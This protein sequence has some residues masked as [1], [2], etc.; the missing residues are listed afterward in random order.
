MNQNLKTVII[1]ASILGVAVALYFVGK[2][3]VKH[4]KAKAEAKRKAEIEA[5]LGIGDS[6]P[7]TQ[8]EEEAA[9][10]Y[11]PSSDVKSLASQIVGGNTYCRTNG[12]NKIVMKLNTSELKILNAAWKKEYDKSLYRYLDD[13]WDNGVPNWANCYPE[14]MNR[15]SN[16]GLR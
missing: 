6:S 9:K 5:E 15:L 2:K 7:A 3:S 12:V 10:S 16:A 8:V 14:A 11:N 4:I 13:E 1:G